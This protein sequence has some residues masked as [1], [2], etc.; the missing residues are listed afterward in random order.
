M[1]SRAYSLAT[2]ART[3]RP[4]RALRVFIRGVMQN[5]LPDTHPFRCSL[6]R[7]ALPAA[8]LLSP[9]FMP[10]FFLSVGF[11]HV[12][13]AP[14]LPRPPFGCSLRIATPLGRPSAPKGLPHPSAYIRS[15]CTASPHGRYAAIRAV[16]GAQKHCFSKGKK[17]KLSAIYA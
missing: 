13:A 16:D 17:C 6:L 11:A 4:L 2:L 3:A 1:K 15:F 14:R 10:I 8:P 9:A 7:F 12:G 5:V